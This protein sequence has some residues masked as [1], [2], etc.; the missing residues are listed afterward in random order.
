MGP[1]T[2]G[3]ELWESLFS[4]GSLAEN[5]DISMFIERRVR[6]KVQLEAV[7]QIGTARPANAFGDVGALEIP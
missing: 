3:D 6:F 2:L 1:K 7:D 5:R 4:T